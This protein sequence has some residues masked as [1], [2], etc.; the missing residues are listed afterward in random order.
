MLLFYMQLQALLHGHSY[1]GHAI[2]CQAAITS[3]KWFS[4]PETNKN[5]LPCGTRLVEVRIA[6]I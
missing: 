1:S 2:G 3:L 6:L 5:L 4:N